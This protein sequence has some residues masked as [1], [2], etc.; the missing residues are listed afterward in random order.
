MN[1]E[2]RIQRVRKAIEPVGQ[3][4]SDWDI[5]CALAKA[6]GR[7][8][9]FEFASAEEIWNEV[10]SACEGARGMSYARLDV[11]GL[12]WPCP[13]DDHPGTIRLHA[14]GFPGGAGPS[15]NASTGSRPRSSRRPSFRF[16]W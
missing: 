11:A 2:R 9:G 14:A 3:A 13:S 6:M 7:P 10:R 5:I 1:A 12:Q 8:E 15:C 16:C 4:R